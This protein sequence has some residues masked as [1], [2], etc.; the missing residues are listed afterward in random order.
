M[1][2][3]INFN[4]NYSGG[5][6]M[7]EKRARVKITSI[8]FEASEDVVEGISRNTTLTRQ[9][10][11]RIK[12]HISNLLYDMLTEDERQRMEKVFDIEID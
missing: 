4:Y 9:K 5:E 8:T 1:C 10:D 3:K 2:N 7:E 6:K 12:W 11:G